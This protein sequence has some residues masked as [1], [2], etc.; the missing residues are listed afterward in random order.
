[1]AEV[2]GDLKKDATYGEKETRRLLGQNLPKEY[3]VYVESPIK[4]ER[5]FRYPD[6]V[7]VT[8]YGFII[9]EVKDWYLITHA[10]PHGATVRTRTGEDRREENPVTK[11]REYGF[12]LTKA[13]NSKWPANLDQ[14]QIPWSYAAVL[15]NLPQAVITQV[16]IPWGEEFVLGKADLESPDELR[17]R[18]KQTMPPDR[19]R[20]L[21]RAELDHLRAIIFPVVDISISGK[22]SFTLD[23]QQEKIVAEPLRPLEK[24]QK[25]LTTDSTVEQANFLQDIAPMAAEEDLPEAGKKLTRNL[26]IR[27]VRGFSGSGKTLVMIQRA[28]YISAINPDWKVGILTFNNLL[29]ENLDGYFK[30]TDIQPKTF[31]SLCKRIVKVDDQNRIELDAWL[32]DNALKYPSIFKLGRDVV[33]REINWIRDV[34]FSNEEEYLGAERKGI[35]K[36][37]RLSLEEKHSIYTICEVFR[38]HLR[39]NHLW[40]WQEL[41]L[42]AWEKVEAGY[43]VE[44]FDALLIDEAQDW[45]PVWFKIVNH[46]IKPE[47]GILFLADDPSQSIYR[48]FS[49]REKGIPVVGRTRWLKVPYRNTYEIYRAAYDLIDGYQEIQDSLVEEGERVEPDISRE[50]MRTGIKPLLRKF[51]TIQEEK[52]YL[53]NVVETYRNQ[54]YLDKQIAIL[55]R[56]NDDLNNIRQRIKGLDIWAETCHSFKGLET[57]VVILPFLHKTFLDASKEAAERR[58]MYMAMSRARSNLVLTYSGRLPTPYQGL[59][60]KSLVDYLAY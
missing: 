48:Y 50:V 54:G 44:Q 22:P 38:D 57:E 13:I 35:G 60:D 26:S 12:A 1:M 39:K 28:R 36:D 21:T 31:H 4:Q 25:Q 19:M 51:N 3:T 8:N 18:L 43:P 45:A 49:W 58:L 17:S 33:S 11:A 7:I 20:S 29:K 10:D 53:R 34:G 52:D 56:H 46:L 42:L 41:P 14:Q 9:L 2:V 55:A 59:L 16:R 37:H 24:P 6:F 30:G 32:K 23:S 27:L 40:D 47:T 15:F 5:D